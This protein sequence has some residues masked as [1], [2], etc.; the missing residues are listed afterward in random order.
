MSAP[1][2]DLGVLHGGI[3]M[4][5]EKQQSTQQPIQKVPVPN[6]LV[7]PITQHVGEPSHPIVGIGEYVLKGQLIAEA[8]G[9]LSA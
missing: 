1:T 9:S 5:A 6:Q 4:P 7:L 3:R 8:C 2:Y